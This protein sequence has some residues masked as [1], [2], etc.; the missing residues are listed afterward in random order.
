M[1]R[2]V[3]MSS[4][5]ASLILSGMSLAWQV[6]VTAAPA[7][8]TPLSAAVTVWQQ[9]DLQSAFSLLSGAIEKGTGDPRAYYFRGIVS[10]QMGGSGDDDF[11]AAARR[12]IASGSSRLVNLALENTQGPLRTRIEL[13]RSEARAA[14]TQN[15]AEATHALQYRQ[16]ITSMKSGDY[17]AAIEKLSPAVAAG[18]RDPRVYYMLGVAQSRT[19]QADAAKESFRKGLSREKTASDV[20][21]VSE[22]L[23][24]VPGDIRRVIEDQV[25]LQEG[26]RIVSRR[27][28]ARSVIQQHQNLLAQREAEAEERLAQ[29]LREARQETAAADTT[30]SATTGDASSADP[31]M[32]AETPDRSEEPTLADNSE[33]AGSPG[34]TPE[35]D[36]SAAL[37]Q[38]DADL[39]AEQ[40]DESP[41][42]IAAVTELPPSRRT[43]SGARP[44]EQESLAEKSPG[45]SGV[46][47]GQIDFS[48]LAPN[49]E[50]VV[51]VNNT[52]L[53]ESDFYKALVGVPALSAAATTKF[54]GILQSSDVASV[55][56]G[57][58]DIMA[59]V[60]ASAMQAG[61]AGANGMAGFQ[62]LASSS[63]AVQ[64]L[65]LSGEIDIAAML[66]DSGAEQK[67]HAGQVYFVVPAGNSGV[68]AMDS[69]EA[70][71]FS[72]ESGFGDEKTEPSAAEDG[73]SD[74]SA[75]GSNAPDN[76][77]F[78]GNTLDAPAAPS[79]VVCVIDSR[80]LLL[81][82]EAGVTAALDRGPGS[83]Q[84]SQFEFVAADGDVVIAFSTPTLAA[85]SGSVPTPDAPVPFVAEFV[86]AVKGNLNGIIIRL[87]ADTDLALNIQLHLTDSAAGAAAAKALNDGLQMANAMYPG[88]RSNVPE[89]LQP[90]VDTAVQ[91]LQAGFREP[92]V[93]V[94]VTIPQQLITVLQE[95]PELLPGPLGG[96]GSP[97]SGFG[98][99]V[100]GFGQ[101]GD[102]PADGFGNPPGESS[103]GFGSDPADSP[104]GD[105]GDG[106]GTP[107]ETESFDG[108]P[109]TGDNDGFGSSD[110]TT[111]SSDGLS[112]PEMT[113]DEPADGN[114]DGFGS[115]P[116][117]ESPFDE[118]PA[119]TPAE[120]KAAD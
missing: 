80:T 28:N 4:R 45:R 82:S 97:D 30:D 61:N 43:R 81:G 11:R 62:Q 58:G 25:T 76:N 118:T 53:M 96:G 117:E 59:T 69:A 68:P 56:I 3:A 24:N 20:R 2:S 64:V 104:A 88:I 108:S 44:K 54:M 33:N 32:D 50:L 114:G 85:M 72:D 17:F 37:N 110:S 65:R 105:A 52:Q 99:P 47:E 84:N 60:V 107:P 1:T 5:V 101:P 111:E 116:G 91:S 93:T 23:Q 113:D 86:D 73:F 34:D 48:W 119:D 9:G 106:F 67:E 6:S 41:R 19:G 112:E 12:E 94:S 57:A 13:I 92:L 71:S 51:H 16:A 115:S 89:P 40:P 38:K 42:E 8:D 109:T 77:A 55:T 103:D 95:S 7:A 31:A 79:S 100:D 98:A 26:E 29:R 78:G 74:S 35:A 49:T 27:M 87:D 21:L 75:P 83:A 14:A 18:A 10:E 120:P 102:A 70:E 15:P 36:S 63:T 22:A 66:Q 46:P 39:S 90:V